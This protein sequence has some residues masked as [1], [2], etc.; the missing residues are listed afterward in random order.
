MAEYVLKPLTPLGGQE[1][2]IDV[3]GAVTISENVDTALASLAI[4]A[5]KDKPFATAAKKALK[6]ALPG[7]GLWVGKDG[8]GAWWT[9]P[10]QWFIE[11]P[12]ASHEDIAGALKP[13]FGENASVTEQSGGWCRFDLEGDDCVGVLQRLC[14]VDTAT[15]KAGAA[16]RSVIEHMGIFIVCRE[17]ATR[18]TIYG[19]RSSAGSLHH[20]LVTAAKSVV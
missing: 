14:A 1:A 17:A 13:V 11:A 2:R 5:G 19:G 12:V 20:A 10:D 16:T 9:S 4:R 8:L 3:I 18:F 7:P 6:F 15:M